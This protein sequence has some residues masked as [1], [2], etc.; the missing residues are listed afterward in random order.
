MNTLNDWV[1][2]VFPITGF[3]FTG[4]DTINF[5]GD[6]TNMTPPGCGTGWNALLNTL[7]MMQAASGSASI[8]VAMLPTGVP[9]GFTG[10]GGGGPRAAAG[11]GDGPTF[12]Q[13][14]GHALGRDHAPCNNPPNVDP[15]YPNYTPM[16]G[17]GEHGF[18]TTALQVFL[19]N[20]T[21]DFMGYCP[22]L[23]VSPY[24]YTGLMNSIGFVPDSP[25]G[26][27]RPEAANVLREWLF[28]T[29]RVLRS[30]EVEL[31]QGFHI[32]A[33]LSLATTH[34][35]GHSSSVSC[36]L[37]DGKG[38]VLA[39]HRCHLS[40]MH[41]ADGDA[42]FLEFQ[43]VIPWDSRV[44]S[45]R[46]LRAGEVCHVGKVPERPPK[47]DLHPPAPDRRERNIMRVKW[48][49]DH[50]ERITACLLRYSADGGVTWRVVALDLTEH[51]CS[52]DMDL[53]PGGDHCLSQVVASA[54]LRTATA[55][56]EP[57]AVPRKAMRAHILS[58][59]PG[60]TFVEGDLVLLRGIGFS[61]DFGTADFQDIVWTS[62]RDGFIGTGYEVLA[63]SLSAGRHKLII[64]FPDRLG[65]E[66]YAS[67]FI[68]V[69]PRGQEG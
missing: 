65:G 58:P 6:L 13:E 47:I 8:Y 25:A 17:I 31:R 39:F 48:S 12:A 14:I 23:W 63:Q 42:P 22:S 61:P 46:F 24:T 49:V 68:T 18:D 64:N 67:A 26:G 38:E 35:G 41:G 32:P 36:E 21:F 9:M 15:N 29:F 69:N 59:E 11:V 7:T 1:R 57:F 16:G 10:C 56:T 53:L 33:E 20:N 19:P 3:N 4:F 2:R 60:A 27:G 30:G 51:Q 44:T 54:G 43:E 62:N 40:D 66:A 50:K 55:Q 34:H 45:I 52:V 5:N 37:L 28:V